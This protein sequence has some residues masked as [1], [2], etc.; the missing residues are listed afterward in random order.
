MSNPSRQRLHVLYLVNDIVHHSK[1]HVSDGHLA[2]ALVQSLQPV[3]SELFQYAASQ[4]KP[5]VVRRL[6]DLINIWEQHRYFTQPQTG[7][8]R[9]SMSHAAAGTKPSTE[10]LE[11][12]ITPLTELPYIMPATHGDSSLPF[13]DLPTANL[14]RLIVPN[15]SQPIR[16]E[17]IKALQFSSGPADESLVNALK[18]FLRDVEKIDNA[19]AKLEDEQLVVEVDE[20]GQI[21]YRNEA[22]DVSGDTYYGWSRSFCEKMKS[23]DRDGNTDLAFRRD[24]S[25]S[26]SRSRSNSHVAR[27][28]R[29]P[30]GSS[31]RYSSPSRSPSSRT[32]SRGKGSQARRNDEHRRDRSRNRSRNRSYSPISSH[33]FKGQGQ[34]FEPPPMPTHPH[35]AL[36]FQTLPTAFNGLPP[37]PPNW[38]GVWPPP[39]PP[40]P[41]YTP[42]HGNDRL[43][44]PPPPSLQ[45]NPAILPFPP[46]LP[47]FPPRHG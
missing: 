19:F 36:P 23:R 42:S 17:E 3:L 15:S 32:P 41:S 45:T 38:T 26:S 40:P 44:F 14:M 11:Q 37:P 29:R 8:L 10:P 2:G 4:S 43:P 22:G 18:D 20:L 28:R 27:K 21:S 33:P 25:R 30:S 1:Y 6:E 34:N 46:G 39:P 35:A 13:Y 7:I 16:P 5:K 9:D 47:P 31:A 24:H 12:S